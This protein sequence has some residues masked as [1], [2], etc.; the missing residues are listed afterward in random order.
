MYYSMKVYNVVICL[1]IY[2]SYRNSFVQSVNNA[3][4][5]IAAPEVVNINSL[6]NHLLKLFNRN[7]TEENGS[8]IDKSQLITLN[9]KNRR[10]TDYIVYKYN[11][12]ENSHTYTA[13][14]PHLIEKV[15]V[16]NELAWQSKKNQYGNK[17]VVTT[18][19]DNKALLTVHFP[20]VP[21]NHG[22][23]GV[24]LLLV[25]DKQSHGHIRSTRRNSE[26]LE[27][28][29]ELQNLLKKIENQK[30]ASQAPPE[31]KPK[32]T[33]HFKSDSE[34]NVSP[35][36]K[37]LSDYELLTRKVKPPQK[38]ELTTLYIDKLSST[39]QINYEYDV[40]KEQHTF[41]PK[42]GYAIS[43]IKT[44][45]ELVWESKDGVYPEQILI[46]PGT[47]KQPMMRMVFDKPQTSPNTKPAVVHPEP[48]VPPKEEKKQEPAKPIVP[49]REELKHEKPEP[50]VP[51]EEESKKE[52]PENIV[53][54]KEEIKN[55]EPRPMSPHKEKPKN[56]PL[57]S[58]SGES[59]KNMESKADNEK[60]VVP[61]TP[62]EP[63]PS[64]KAPESQP[65]TFP[66]ESS[67]FPDVPE[68]PVAK[69]PE[70]EVNKQTHVPKHQLSEPGEPLFK[71]SKPE[72]AKVKP[73]IPNEPTKPSPQL[74]E[75]EKVGVSEPQP[76]S[77]KEAVKSELN[78]KK[79]VL[80][81]NSTS[82]TD[83]YDYF[84]DGE[85]A[86]YETKDNHVFVS[87]QDAKLFKKIW[88]AKDESEYA[89]KVVR[90][91]VDILLGITKLSVFFV[92]GQ[93]KHFSN[94][95]NVWKEVTNDVILD[96]NNQTYKYEYEFKDFPQSRFFETKYDFRFKKIKDGENIIWESEGNHNANMV[97]INGA[98]SKNK[99]L[100][101]HFSDPHIL[102]F[103]KKNKEP[104]VQ[105]K[106]FKSLPKS[107]DIKVPNKVDND[108]FTHLAKQ[109]NL[110]NLI[111]R[112][113]EVIWKS[114][115]YNENAKKVVVYA[116]NKDY[117]FITIYP[118]KGHV[119]KLLKYPGDECKEIDSSTKI[120][121]TINIRSNKSSC[122]Y[123]NY[124]RNNVRM[125]RAK[126]DHLFAGVR[127]KDDSSS[128]R[129]NDKSIWTASTN[130]DNDSRYA[131][132]VEVITYDKFKDMYEVTVYLM[133]GTTRK[134]VRQETMPWTF[135]DPNQKLTVSIN[136]NSQ[137]ECYKYSL[138]HKNG[139]KVFTAKPGIAFNGVTYVD[140]GEAEVWD[141]KNVNDWANRV[142][143]D[144]MGGDKKIIIYLQ[145]GGKKV[146]TRK[147]DKKW[148]EEVGAGVAVTES[149]TNE[150]VGPPTTATK[151]NVQKMHKPEYTNDV[152]LYVKDP[153]NPSSNKEMDSKDYEVKQNQNR[154]EFKL[155]EG[156]KCTEVKY[157]VK[158]TDLFDRNKTIGL[159]P[160]TVWKRFFAK[161]DE[162]YPK[163]VVYQWPNKIVIN[164]DTFFIV[165]EKEV[166]GTW[167]NRNFDIKFY[168][169]STENGNKD[170]VEL[171]WSKYELRKMAGERYDYEFKP[172]TKCVEVK[173]MFKKV[174]PSDQNRLI[175]GYR[176]VW[177]YGH[178]GHK[179]YPTTVS[180]L[181]EKR[182]IIDLGTKIIVSERSTDERWTPKESYLQFFTAAGNR[183]GRYA[184]EGAPLSD[185]KYGLQKKG[186]ELRY[187]FNHGI[188]CTT[189]TH[190]ECVGEPDDINKVTTYY[191]RVWVYDPDV[192]PGMYPK[193][194]VYKTGSKITIK[195]DELI[196]VYQRNVYGDWINSDVFDM[197]GNR[198]PFFNRQPSFKDVTQN[199]EGVT[200]PTATP[201][202]ATSL[203]ATPPTESEEIAP[204]AAISRSNGITLSRKGS[205]SSNEG[206][207]VPFRISVK[208][209]ATSNSPPNT[210]EPPNT[211]K[212]P[213]SAT[214]PDTSTTTPE[215]SSAP[216]ID[217]VQQPANSVQQPAKGSAQPRR[218]SVQAETSSVQAETSIVPDNVVPPNVFNPATASSA[219]NST[220]NANGHPTAN[221]HATEH[222]SGPV[223]Q[224]VSHVPVQ[225]PSNN[226]KLA[227]APHGFQSISPNVN[228]VYPSEYPKDVTIITQGSPNANDINKYRV[229]TNFGTEFYLYKFIEGAKCVEVRHV[230][231][232]ANGKGDD[233]STRG[234]AKEKVVWTYN[235]ARYG[236]KYPESVFYN[237]QKMTFIIMFDDHNIICFKRNGSW[238]V[239][240]STKTY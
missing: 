219:T 85:S 29:R 39:N 228:E 116:I 92:N 132:K 155:K 7:Q 173:Y 91:G 149:A 240:G 103:T 21:S 143:L 197:G 153:K 130:V 33:E 16:G 109:G 126:G 202:T 32:P 101:I 31:T 140:E 158:I 12:S 229:Y 115:S 152:K 218:V 89:T 171:D 172:G 30:E 184:E 60:V 45:N 233:K 105:D 230:E 117:M 221:A 26:S 104:W 81:I 181:S 204:V 189:V 22:I 209:S 134:Y 121:I 27:A 222:V 193:S 142:E 82:S 44:G 157:L 216:T 179:E 42:P 107:L 97:L 159:K 163:S 122:A 86:I 199:T 178:L 169:M 71:E 137:F 76:R 40:A 95:E 68:E 23:I 154:Y 213:K 102:V 212:P 124:Q 203:T 58:I 211:P 190:V 161:S 69:H 183:N 141:A 146:F 167:V 215:I 120:P 56:E 139:L 4:K 55:E 52:A 46:L 96:I 231:Q 200:P 131:N 220:S 174:D 176:T 235:S 234:P 113:K 188:K 28:L 214:Q 148:V 156:S 119:T 237:K 186:D 138:S 64:A 63:K 182:L 177:K 88:E 11:P 14:P 118:L 43:A 18:D 110:F 147:D 98:H 54:P 175:T 79:A 38:L 13:K 35:R 112:G 74:T 236:R 136:V 145:N 160:I 111:K 192:N 80:D 83:F 49:P 225:K 1:F 206:S 185:N 127:E 57:Y 36:K 194:I 51:V 150:E 47:D 62:V 19:K 170:S 34:L 25:D 135:V 2:F 165:N 90:D 198:R 164:F 99:V 73:P 144:M 94:A 114:R 207:T 15:T 41:T 128:D 65:E 238:V 208:P 151:T 48:V 162:N 17:V 201:S 196:L 6:G 87:I 227:S 187:I 210:A 232:G 108:I 205:T 239:A 77:D 59:T 66:R 195:L 53:P 217:S 37:S 8:E 123:Y 3:F 125:F 133:D 10:T 75:P 78:D 226:D 191:K 100:T 9:V 72:P 24:D 84:Q 93:I 129:T 20:M 50:I 61:P 67:L 223:A 70:P 168:T 5:N 180:Y 106:S 166:S 224:P